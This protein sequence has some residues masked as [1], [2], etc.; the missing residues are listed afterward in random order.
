MRIIP[1]LA[2]LIP[3]YMSLNSEASQDITLPNTHLFPE[4][5]SITNDGTAYIGSMTGGV[6]RVSMKN[7]HSE[8]WIEPGSNGSG[9]IF[10]VFADTLNNILWVCSND[11]SKVGIHVNGEKV[12]DHQLIGFDLKTGVGKINLSL[13]GK[14]PIC[15]DI[16]V[17][18]DGSVFITDSSAPQILRWKPQANALEVWLND[19]VFQSPQGGGLD[20]IS[21]A[22]D[23]NLYLSN[24]YS[25]QLYR[26]LV[27]SDG[28]AGLVTR[29]DLSRELIKPD[30]L[31]LIKD[32]DFALSEGGGRI[33]IVSID[34]EKAEV[35][36]I[37]SGL[38]EPTGIDLYGDSLWYVEGYSTWLFH[39][40]D[41][42]PPTLPFR[43]SQAKVYK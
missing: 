10:G 24:F 22:E 35:K 43:L 42:K 26:V 34:G 32:K 25:G 21:F 11:Y 33:D 16:T 39:P 38:Q 13:P 6:L 8:T 20:G 18:K 3:L 15:N 36:T 29:L 4:S 40:G 27:D 23:G 37:L 2:G 30:G 41:G 28:K 12:N 19:P 7:G 17:A 5:I 31:R 9:S 14:T 1:I